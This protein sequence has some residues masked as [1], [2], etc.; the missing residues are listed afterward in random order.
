MEMRCARQANKAQHALYAD[1]NWASEMARA[2][3]R[4]TGGNGISGP[5]GIGW[6]RVRC[7]RHFRECVCLRQ[8]GKAEIAKD[9]N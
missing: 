1:R 3:E 7:Q 2:R 9:G 5:Q 8:Q 4:E 6:Q